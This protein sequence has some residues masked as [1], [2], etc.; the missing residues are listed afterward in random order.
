MN[1]HIA[2]IKLLIGK[3]NGLG[4]FRRLFGWRKFKQ[5]LIE[6]SASITHLNNE[7]QS[8]Q[9]RKEELARQIL[10]G[11]HD[12]K[13]LEREKARLENLE[14]RLNESILSKDAEVNRLIR[15][16][17]TERTKREGLE[18]TARILHKELGAYK[19]RAE[20]AEAQLKRIVEENI[21][22]KRDEQFRIR[23]YEENVAT[24]NSLRE[25]IQKERQEE[26]D[27]KLREERD[28]MEALKQ[29]WLHHQTEVQNRI[30][31][32]CQKHTIQYVDKVPFRG[33]PITPCLFAG[34]MWSSMLKAR[35]ERTFPIFPTI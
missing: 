21:Q 12:L 25:Q 22:L 4:L 18:E 16:L 28:R 5:E 33:E 29:T 31:A 20:G 24:L 19:E 30:K 3:I 27:L 13:T 23:N 14:F 11:S 15:E 10:Q 26:T 34:S 2:K 8:L 7:L 9:D 32:L 6:I 1:E 35:W 17:S